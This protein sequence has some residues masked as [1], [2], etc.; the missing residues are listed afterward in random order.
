MP[1]IALPI[2]YGLPDSSRSAGMVLE[3]ARWSGIGRVTRLNLVQALSSSLYDT[4]GPD[5]DCGV[6]DDNSF[7]SGLYAYPYDLA[8]TYDIGLTHGSLSEMVV[9]EVTVRELVQFSLDTEQSL[10]YPAQKI[11]SSEWAATPWG[12]EGEETDPPAISVE[13]NEIAISKPVYG[14]VAVEYLAIRHSRQMRISPRADAVEDVFCS[15]A[16]ARWVGGCELLK[17][18]PPPKAE[19]SYAIGVTCFGGGLLRSV[20]DDNTPQDPTERSH[21]LEVNVDYCTQV[22]DE[23]AA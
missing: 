18:E 23:E 17:I 15:Y 2:T 19:E 14:S 6:E 22:A 7:E 21:E 8:M 1:T 10:K 16:W 9:Q 11:I 20:D 3:Q 13:G 4:E 12:T 5:V